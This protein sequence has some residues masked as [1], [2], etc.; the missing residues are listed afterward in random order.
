MGNSP[1]NSAPGRSQKRRQNAHVLLGREDSQIKLNLDDDQLP[2]GSDLGSPGIV[3]GVGSRDVA[4]DSDAQRATPQQIGAATVGGSA[5]VGAPA[6]QSDGDGG[7][8]LFGR[9]A[10]SPGSSD[11]T[12]T[13]YPPYQSSP[14]TTPGSPLFE[15]H[16]QRTCH[17][18]G[19]SAHDDFEQS[20]ERIELYFHPRFHAGVFMIAFARHLAW[21]LSFL[22]SQLQR[23]LPRISSERCLAGGRFRT[24]MEFHLG[25]L[26]LAVYIFMGFS[27]GVWFV[28]CSSDHFFQYCEQEGAL[29]CDIPTTAVFM[30]FALCIVRAVYRS[31]MEAL[32]SPLVLES[33]RKLHAKRRWQS[34]K[35]FRK[36]HQRDYH[37]AAE[38]SRALA[39]T[40]SVDH[41]VASLRYPLLQTGGAGTSGAFPTYIVVLSQEDWK[42]KGPT[43]LLQLSAPLKADWARFCASCE[44][45]EDSGKSAA[46]LMAPID[47]EDGKFKKGI[48][49]QLSEPGGVAANNLTEADLSWVNCLLIRPQAKHTSEGQELDE[50]GNQR[51]HRFRQ[52]FISK[53][54]YSVVPHM[55]DDSTW[56]CE[57]QID[58]TVVKS[59]EV[60]I[61][62]LLTHKLA[63]ADNGDI[64]LAELP[65]REYARSPRYVYC[66]AIATCSDEGKLK[67]MCKFTIAPLLGLIHGLIPVIFVEE[68]SRFEGGIVPWLVILLS[69]LAGAYWVDMIVYDLIKAYALYRERK[70][71]QLAISM[72]YDDGALWECHDDPRYTKLKRMLHESIRV[73]R[74]GVLTSDGVEEN[75]QFNFTASDNGRA[76]LRSWFLVRR[77]MSLLSEVC[78]RDINILLGV[79]LVTQFGAL[80]IPVTIS[81][82]FSLERAFSV[83][84]GA[85][86]LYDTLILAVLAVL[87]FREGQ[88]ANNR[89]A[90]DKVKLTFK[91]YQ[92][93]TALS[94]NSKYRRSHDHT[95]T[96]E[97]Q[98]LEM[99][100]GALGAVISCMHVK[101][102]PLT[103]LGFPLTVQSLS[104]F[105][106]SIATFFIAVLATQL[107]LHFLG[108]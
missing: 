19:L 77:T 6:S 95:L 1:S 97:G 16:T 4:P 12:T 69:G 46:W 98:H 14:P 23:F 20:I 100:T 87:V 53:S 2:R 61:G 107:P 94:C 81:I 104:V 103:L 42:S 66:H 99:L 32:F 63:K 29:S 70:H 52:S 48:P 65:V 41:E 55:S 78:S 39:V 108:C 83:D 101:D 10:L 17:G 9:E 21:P 28:H 54:V 8:G 37:T 27:A 11:P 13:P 47:K 18:V 56:C 91:K 105:S 36:R 92:I 50:P 59:S 71:V 58:S 106:G 73:L 72:L 88:V 80:L 89:Q 84:L 93:Q 76:D 68:D 90:R 49:L 57:A 43:D 5:P 96:D 15:A 67:A 24:D 85:Q 44:G 38:R 102:R 40:S 86:L 26:R 7:G 74:G 31:A 79:L 35:N 45:D 51:S 75:W 62:M 3:G 33:T 30:P 60:T 82:H 22:L 34:M 64:T 25:L